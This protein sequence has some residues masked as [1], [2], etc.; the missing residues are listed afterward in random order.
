MVNKAYFMT[1]LKKMEEREIP[2]PTAGAGQAVIKLEYIG[3]CGSDVHYLE[4]GR[5]GDFVV[6]GDFIL[7]HECAGI[8]TEI[9]SLEFIEPARPTS[10]YDD[11][12]QQLA[13]FNASRDRVSRLE[14][15][16]ATKMVTMLKQI[17]DLHIDISK[18][19]AADI[20]S[21]LQGK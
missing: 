18:E 1:D 16:N 17:K 13:T 15:E 11:S 12:E 21:L 4:N 14:A 6:C 8:V 20:E 10:S 5:I 19:A 3:I 7:G 2:M 9:P